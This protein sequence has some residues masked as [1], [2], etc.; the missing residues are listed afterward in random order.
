MANHRTGVLKV[1]EHCKSEFYVKVGRIDRTRF[2]SK[3]CQLS[4]Y[5]SEVR[6]CCFCGQEFK[7]SYTRAR[8]GGG[9]YCSK[10][11][12]NKAQV[13]SVG[14]LCAECGTSFSVWK[15]RVDNGGA[16]YCSQRCYG[17]ARTLR[18][19]RACE[20]CGSSFSVP[21]DRVQKGI[22]RFCSRKCAAEAAKHQVVVACA[23]C[24]NEFET[25]PNRIQSGRGRYCSKACYRRH[26]G[27]GESGVEAIMRRSLEAAGVAYGQEVPLGPYTIDFVIGNVALEIDG[28]FWHALPGVKEKDGR[29]DRVL[30]RNGYQVLR[31]SEDQVRTDAKAIIVAVQERG[32]GI[33]AAIHRVEELHIVQ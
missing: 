9:Y 12:Q 6:N 32:A 4:H 24:G 11:C 5:P 21:R 8:T 18:V 7:C 16:I 14:R 15:S 30:L 1:C 28:E 19:E 22:G 26:V 3:V 20:A 17:I 25:P 2:C 10:G 29:K 13:T 33:G 23:C 31:V 27:V